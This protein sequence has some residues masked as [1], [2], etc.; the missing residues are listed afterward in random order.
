M[1]PIEFYHLAVAMAPHA[2]SEGWQRTVVGR[3]YYGLHHEACCRFY[4]E[5]PTAAPL[6]RGNRHASLL[7]PFNQPANARA[8]K[9]ASLLRQLRH[10]RTQADYELGQM[11]IGRRPVTGAQILNSATHVAEQLRAAL[12]SFSPGEAPEGCTC[13]VSQ[14]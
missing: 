9:V 12:E 5:N 10:V 1:R 7:R 14:I 3:L 6:G 4:R 13:K 2:T 8:V 11:R